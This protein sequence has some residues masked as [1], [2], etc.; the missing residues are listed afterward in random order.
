MLMGEDHF[1]LPVS[2][3]YYHSLLL[4]LNNDTHTQLLFKDT[5]QYNSI[6][7]DLHSHFIKKL[8]PRDEHWQ[9]KKE[10]DMILMKQPR[11]Q[12]SFPSVVLMLRISALLLLHQTVMCSL[13]ELSGWLSIKFSCILAIVQ[14][15]NAS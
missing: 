11:P 13:K 15:R 5:R 9:K 2:H 4:I 14:L 12:S 8:S 1:E 3:L 7:H 6:S 10:I